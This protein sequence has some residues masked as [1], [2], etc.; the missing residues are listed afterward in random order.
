MITMTDFATE[1]LENIPARQRIL[2]SNRRQDSYVVLALDPGEVNLGVVVMRMSEES[3]DVQFLA[4]QKL[5]GSACYPSR[6][7]S[8]KVPLR[9][10]IESL[11]YMLTDICMSLKVVPDTVLIES[12][13]GMR[14]S[15]VA[16]GLQGMFLGLGV[17]VKFEAA[18][19]L[20]KKRDM[21]MD[22]D[23]IKRPV[24]S[25]RIKTARTIGKHYNT[26]VFR[27]LWPTSTQ[28]KAGIKADD[29][30]D[31]FIYAYAHLIERELDIRHNAQQQ[32]E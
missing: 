24:L 22:A 15:S 10:I 32:H 5:D 25:A 17:D 16:H 19:N 20:S 4:A 28:P 23:H 13:Y 26:H 3:T 29:V 14:Q 11:Y 12:Q 27:A 18:V 7:K 31:A 21:I 2:Y 9:Y 6:K 1:E 8:T 30:A